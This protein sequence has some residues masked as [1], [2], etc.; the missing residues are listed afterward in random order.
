MIKLKLIQEPYVTGYDGAFFPEYTEDGKA[1]VEGWFDA[2]FTAQAV[3]ENGNEYKVFWKIVNENEPEFACDW[4]NSVMILDEHY[5]N[6][7]DKA[8]LGF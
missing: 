1:S 3:D 4:D 2:M 8:T 5:R 6:I 7:V